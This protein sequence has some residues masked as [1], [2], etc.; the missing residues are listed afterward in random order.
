[1]PSVTDTRHDH[2]WTDVSVGLFKPEGQSTWRRTLWF[3]TE[4]VP[5]LA[6]ARYDGREGRLYFSMPTVREASGAPGGQVMALESVLE[7]EELP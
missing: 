6:H 4:S 7:R 3:N 5:C 2:Q 1:M